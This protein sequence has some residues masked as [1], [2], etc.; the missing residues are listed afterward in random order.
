M[1]KIYIV[2]EDSLFMNN[3]FEYNANI[4][5]VTADKELAIKKLKELR[6]SYINTFEIDEN[7]IKQYANKE[8]EDST[9]SIEDNELC[10]YVFDKDNGDRACIKINEFK[11]DDYLNYESVDIQE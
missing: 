10:F 7:Y 5:L 4:V 2:T 8:Q 1:N 3:V 6:K 11:T 9:L